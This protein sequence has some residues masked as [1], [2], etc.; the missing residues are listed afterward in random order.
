MDKL[1]DD[2]ELIC[3]RFACD[4]KD[5]GHSLDV[6][7]ELAD[8]RLVMC[9]LNLYMAGKAPLSW[10]IKQAWCCLKGKDGQLGEFTVCPEDIP[11]LIGILKRALT[12]Y[13]N[14]DGT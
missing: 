2:S 5:Q 12:I 1:F 10:R 6:G 11:H 8:G 14:T 3:E 13:S 4:C 9:S 7:V